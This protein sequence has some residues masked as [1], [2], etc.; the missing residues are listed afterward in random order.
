MLRALDLLTHN[1]LFTQGSRFPPSGATEPERRQKEIKTMSR[2]RQ[3]IMTTL[4]FVVLTLASAATTKA[5]PTVVVDRTGLG[6]NTATID[7]EGPATNTSSGVPTSLTFMGVTFSGDSRRANAGVEVVAPTGN[8]NNPTNALVSTGNTFFSTAADPIF[9]LV[10]TLPAGTNAIGFDIKN[11]N[12]EGSGAGS[13]EI[14]VNGALFQT[15]ATTFST[16]SFFGVSDMSGI[17]SISIRS[18]L[19]GDP[20]IDNV[21]FGPATETPEPATMVLLGTGLAGMAAAARRRRRQQ[22][23][24]VALGDRS[25]A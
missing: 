2:M 19:G 13:Y 25:L 1:D 23:Q 15:V 21:T 7:F 9:N 10:I 3:T 24:A 4:A 8:L 14:Y 18:L 16:F 22:Q 11:A 6:A 20:V 17:N 12:G 5:V